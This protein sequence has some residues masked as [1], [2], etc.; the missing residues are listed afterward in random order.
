GQSPAP[1]EDTPENTLVPGDLAEKVTDARRQLEEARQL[2]RDDLKTEN[3]T[4]AANADNSQNAEPP[5]NN[6]SN[7]MQTGND[8]GEEPG[9][10]ESSTTPGN[11]QQQ[12]NQPSEGQKP[13]QGQPGGQQPGQNQPGQKSSLAQS[14]QKLQEAA[15]S[16]SQAAQEL[17]AG[18]P[19]QSGSRGQSQ[20]QSDNSGSNS[21]GA[22]SETGSQSFIPI[23][24]LEAELQ[25]QTR[26]EWG[27]LPGQ[28]RTEILQG[29]KKQ[30]GGDYA[31][32]IKLYSEEL[33]KKQQD[34]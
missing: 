17:G 30:P 34:K 21:S 10:S 19:G 22:D 14:A 23:E 29:N 7:P 5:S 4:Q 28:L 13:G 2:L 18:T 27:T 20:S 8:S 6:Q 3:S 33:L 9:D 15:Q 12:N 16:L 32:L 1:P 24:E 31:R 26:E 11:K 25:R